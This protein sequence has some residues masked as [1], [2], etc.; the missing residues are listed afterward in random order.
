MKRALIS[1]FNC[2]SIPS[3]VFLEQGTAP[4][5]K[6]PGRVSLTEQHSCSDA[7]ILMLSFRWV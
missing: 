5:W 1:Q 4:H 3:T 2:S 7:E 6:K